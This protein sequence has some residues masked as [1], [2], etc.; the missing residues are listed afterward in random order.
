[1]RKVIIGTR[2]SKLALR[3][4]EEIKRTLEKSNP[5]LVVIFKTIRVKGDV[6]EDWRPGT[7]SSEKGLFVK[8]I[9]D[10]LLAGEIDLAVHSMKDVP[11]ELPQKLMIAAITKRVDPR[12]VLISRDGL[13]LDDLPQNV[14]VG[15]SSLR[16]KLQLLFYR[17]DL[18]I[19]PLR[20][21]LDTRLRKLKEK[22]IDAIVIAAAGLIRLGWQNRITQYLPYE[23]MLPAGGQG[24]LGIEIREEDEE[25][26]R[27]SELLND[28]DSQAAITAERHFLRELGGGCQVPVA[29]LGQVQGEKLSLEAW[30]STSNGEKTLRQKMEGSSKNPEK[31]GL[32]LADGM[33][34]KGLKKTSSGFIFQNSHP[35]GRVYLVGAGPGDPG[36]ITL[37]GV[38]C[39]K[40][41]DIVIYDRL[42]NKKT[43]NY[44][45]DSCKLLY[46][47][48]LPGES[49]SQARIN[50][51]MVRE[52]RRGRIVVRL[53]GGDPFLLGRGAEEVEFLADSNIDF[54]VIPGISSA[55]AAPTYAGIPLTHRNFSS[56]LTIATGHEDP[57]KRKSGVNWTRLARENG[58]LVILMG[59]ANFPQIVRRLISAGRNQ[60]TPCAVINWGT[61][62]TQKVVKGTLGEMVEKA[63]GVKP[64]GV[65][66]IGEVVSL[67]EKLDW[68]EKKP[69]FG[70]QMLITRSASQAKNLV[71]LLEDQGAEVVEFPTI[72]I[73]SLNEYKKLDL[74]IER[75]ADYDWII[76]TSPNGVDHFW[77]RMKMKGKDAR[78]LCK[79]KI[80]GIGPKTTANLENMGIMA[81][82]LPDEYS[83]EGIIKGIERFKIK[84][85][86]I[87]L[88]RADIAPSRLPNGLRKLGA[89]VEEV[90]VYETQL[91]EGQNFAALR[92]RLRNRKIDIIVFTS[93]STVRNFVKLIGD[94]DVEGAR[95]AC[96]GPMTASEAEKSGMKPDIVPQ[97]YTI[98]GLVEEIVNVLSNS[99]TQKA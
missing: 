86:K 33:I 10:A 49:S 23:I 71:G 79:L 64:P 14:R 93:S 47:G 68:F 22:E 24:A 58:T 96:I 26:R 41:A 95:I 65:I 62:P 52:A 61:T 69:L 37:K 76:F 29:T 19:V 11:T 87:L 39:I 12:D 4:A 59:L 70:K 73:S 20:G 1:M 2:A 60:N 55:L 15:T 6:L 7:G 84:G 98:E 16:R 77:R 90:A 42:I 80:G 48:K 54:E 88:P 94:I 32:E 25:I 51:M 34:G 43:L 45:K 85:K 91:P 13:S 36:L 9:E 67:R 46:M 35:G 92:N 72:K 38:E 40:K 66:I 8:E 31:V 5:G 74:V 30:V 56:S 57:Q 53:K 18:Q 17:R 27:I 83:T 3:Q 63:K 99:S 21:N 97:E 81:D 44:A 89:R 28:D 78:S 50:E 82:F 75:L